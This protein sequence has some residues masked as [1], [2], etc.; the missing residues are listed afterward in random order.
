MARGLPASYI[1]KWGVSKKAWREYR[2]VHAKKKSS[3]RK[4]KTSRAKSS[5]KRSVRKT[6]RKRSNPRK[7]SFSINT[8]FK[9]IRLGALIAP[10]YGRYAGYGGGTRGFQAALGGFAGVQPDGS[11]SGAMF[12][13]SWL[14]YL[15]AC[16]ATHG[17]GKLNGIIRD[18]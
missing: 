1:K 4:K 10:A 3:T 8:V 6:A 7:R 18:L 16:L 15:L 9:Y 14:P 11:F 5:R 13:A 12:K 2:K 17:I